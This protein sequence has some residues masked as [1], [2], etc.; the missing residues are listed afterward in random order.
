MKKFRKEREDP[1]A[2]ADL[3]NRASR[4]RFDHFG[5]LAPFYEFFIP[6]RTSPLFINAV[7]NPEGG[8]FLDAGG[9]TGRVAQFFQGQARLIVVADES[10]SMLQETVK[11]PGLCA[12]CAA[13]ENLP[14]SPRA[15]DRVVMVD[16]LHHV[17][18]Q[19]AA[20]GELWRIVKPGGRVVIEEPDI[21][22]V[23]VKLI[24]LAEKLL[25]MRS[26]FLSPPQI[27]ALFHHQD[28]G[29]CVEGDRA[30]A[31]VIID[32]TGPHA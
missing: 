23:W 2:D 7:N 5:I 21:R 22:S 4:T 30:T 29:V 16:A 31:L 26:R 27:S 19:A 18:D 25:L 20:C 15:F 10:T 6:P 32:K 1:S 3:E 13:A 12:V 17:A 8:L 9:G 24:A 14:F 28:A 11:K